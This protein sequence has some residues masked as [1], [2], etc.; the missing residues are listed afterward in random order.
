MILLTISKQIT[1]QSLKNLF[2]SDRFIVHL[3][4]FALIV[5][6]TALG[7][8]QLSQQQLKPIHYGRPQLAPK[9]KTAP[10][11][12]SPLT[13]SDALKN[14]NTGLL[15]PAAVPHT[16]IPDRTVIV[17]EVQT[18]IVQP[19]DTIYGIA[20]QFALSPETIQW[21]NPSLEDN[22]DLLSVGQEL[23]VLPIDGVYHQVGSDDTIE[24]IAAR[25]NRRL[26]MAGQWTHYPGILER[27]PRS[28]CWR[29]DRRAHLR[30]R[31]RLRNRRP[32]V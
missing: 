27:T 9:I 30:R 26:P 8:W 5:S 15:L 28:G 22:P 14:R 23:T 20:D 4:I 16:I 18:Y 12:G 7:S 19:G 10:D 32:V 13:L 11:A 24:G 1:S 25:G 29:L 21:S 31:F 17:E 3:I 6:I 2:Q